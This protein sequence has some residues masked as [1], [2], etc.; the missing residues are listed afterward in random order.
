MIELP[1]GLVLARQMD[2]ELTGKRIAQIAAN[3][4]PHKFAWYTGDPADYPVLFTGKMVEG[5]HSYGGNV[6]LRVSE[7]CGLMFCD[8]TCLRYYT[9]ADKAPKKHQLCITFDD[10]TCLVGTVQMYG[11]LASYTGNY[12]NPYDEAARTRPSPLSDAFDRAYFQA[13]V[14]ADKPKL[15]AKA[16][17][18]TEQ[19]I[20]GL[21]NGV[22]QD[23]LFAAGVQPR[24]PV[25]DMSAEEFD[26]LFG[27]VKE[28]LRAMTEKGGR[29][30]ERDLYGAP[31]GYRTRLSKNTWR[32]PCPQCGGAIVK[33]AYLGGSVYYCPRCQK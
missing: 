1:E 32:S 14:P 10:G 19:R 4:S 33:E 6:H 17:L 5:A 22:A 13:L 16:L 25:S 21:G 18:A 15:S 12:D 31:G 29:D 20:P 24:R 28:T 27:A 3:T 30:V 23:I 11:S 9:A 2:Q 26:R 8:G 7:D